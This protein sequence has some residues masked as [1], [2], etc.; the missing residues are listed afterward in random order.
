MTCKEAVYSEQVLDYLITNYRGEEFVRQVYEPDCYLPLDG[1]QAVIYKE[2]DNI[3]SE[4]I[5]RFGFS[6]IPNVYGLM[7]EAALEESGVLQIRRQPYLDLYGQGI[8]IG[9][10]DTGIDFTHEAF[11]NADNTTRIVSLWD[12]TIKSGEGDETF[13]Y[14]RMYDREELNEALAVE[15]PF[16]MV[17]SRD[18][19][20][21]GTFLAGVAAG[22]ENRQ[23]EFSGV[24]P[25]SEL[26]IVKCK[27]TKQ[28]Y[29]DYYRIPVEVPAYQENDILAGI[30]YILKIA[31][32]EE[33]PVIICFGMGSN[34]GS[35]DG[36]TYLSLF[37]ERYAA[38]KGI[39]M[40]AAIGNEGNTR[41]HH[42]I[43]RREDTINI[44]VERSLDGFMTQ[45]WWRT[46]GSVLLDFISPS[47]EIYTG[48]RATVGERRTLRFNAENTVLEL[49]FAQSQEISSEQVV[50]MRFLSPKA[51]IWKI[52]TTADYDEPRYHIWLP[53]KQFLGEEVAFLEPN[54]NNT[55]CN[56]GTGTYIITISAYDVT[57]DSLYLQ[58]GRGFTPAGR[59]KPEVVAPGVNITGP[60]PGNRYGSMTGTG[61]AAAFAAGIGALFFQQ[62][63]EYNLNGIMLRE[64]FIQGAKRRGE[65][66]PNTEWGYG[67]VDAYASV[68]G[69]S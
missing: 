5:G 12:Q 14:G 61:V 44:N 18:E 62:Y 34:M 40:I 27:E 11:I 31:L 6:S 42:A 69:G 1:V 48:I 2:T 56:P 51:G 13:P 20:G 68:T 52:R 28:I 16:E 60:Y 65:S 66:F 63:R 23:E 43:T 53:I 10:V 26:V 47:G 46:P 19:N 24:A 3:N 8:L 35:H 33:K 39:G 21:H 22:N 9:F 25:L 54:P 64:V 37:M 7:S 30:A 49:F 50:S 17:E 41:H 15:N 55:L 67:I 4:T 29:R 38:V 59:I 58:A 36:G 57:E 45:L 32:R